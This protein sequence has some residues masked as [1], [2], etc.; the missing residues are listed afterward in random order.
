MNLFKIEMMAVFQVL[1]D[2]CYLMTTQT[3][4]YSIN[5]VVIFKIERFHIGEQ[6]Q[7]LDVYLYM[8]LI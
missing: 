6:Y 5:E 7:V 2:Q 4:N 3:L 8:T 1:L